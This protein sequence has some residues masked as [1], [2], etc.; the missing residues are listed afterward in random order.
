MLEDTNATAVGA[1]DMESEPA[2]NQQ[3]AAGS[4]GPKALNDNEGFTPPY[5]ISYDEVKPDE[6][7]PL[8]IG[9]DAEWIEEPEEPSD[10]TDADDPPDPDA[11]RGNL[12]LSYQYAC[13]FSGREW[14]G[15]VYTRAGARIRYPDLNEQ[16]VADYPV[17]IRFADLLGEAISAGTKAG[18]LRKWPK[19][20]I[21]AAHWTRADL[22][23]MADFAEIKREFD[24]VQKTYVTMESRYEARI[25]AG[26]RSRSFEV[27]LL[28]TQL[29]VPGATKGLG[30]L[31]EMYGFPKL[32]PGR[33]AERGGAPYIEHMDWLLEDDPSHFEGYAIKDA[34]ICALHVERMLTFARDDLG[35]DFRRPPITLGSLAV[36][37]LEKRWE[38]EGIAPGAVNGFDLV[39][40]RQFNRNNGKGYITK[41]A[42][43]PR[44]KYSIHE[45]LAKRCFH[46]G[47]NECFWY[48]PTSEMSRDL[49]APVVDDWDGERWIGEILFRE[50]DLAAAYATAL[51]SLRIPDYDNARTT[52]DPA[53]FRP[54]QLGF[55]YIRFGFP[56]ETTCFPCLPVIASDERGLVYP[57]SGE[58]YVTAPE[59]A[60]A[61]HTG[62]EI[63]V[64]DGAVI[65]WIEDSPRPFEL[66]IREL[67]RRRAEHPAGTLQNEMFKQ[68]GNSL[69]GKLGQGI[70]GSTSYNTRDDQRVEIG[71]SRITNPYLAAHVTG[72]IRALVSEMIAS[73]P[74]RWTV[75]SVT[76]DGFVTNAPISDIGMDGPVAT[77]LVGV[78]SSLTQVLMR[79]DLYDTGRGLLEV[80]YEAAW[81][82]PWRTRGVATLSRD[83]D[84]GR[85]HEH[86]LD[87]KKAPK[88]K[89]ARA[90]MREPA[91]T[92]DGNAWFVRT[93]LTREP[94]Q[95]YRSK[96]PLPFPVAHQRSA[97]HRFREL[98]R[99]MNFE[100]DFKRQLVDPVPQFVS[101]PSVG[102]EEDPRIVQHLCCNTIP[103]RT[104]TEFNAARDRFEQWR[105]KHGGQLRTLADWHRWEQFQAGTVASQNG[106]RRSKDGV[107]GQAAR[108]FRRAYVRR[109][110][111]LPG[112]SYKRAADSL[113]AAGYP[114]KEQDFK[115]ALRDKSR[116]PEH[117]IPADA[118]GVRELVCA[119][120]AIWP[121][122]DWERVV[123]DPGLDYLRKT[124][125]APQVNEPQVR[126]NAGEFQ[127]AV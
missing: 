126:G 3:P 30:A 4:R 114:T 67:S 23:A 1:S 5:E 94:G 118:P 74:D 15:I 97:D 11:L 87:P 6:N 34:Q 108:I 103:W 41:T 113:T 47:R 95:K 46:G 72:L 105:H 122:F 109:K 120:L 16:E 50:F 60:L 66:V 24:G 42:R 79:Q 56:A 107:V 96:E 77:H 104:V 85:K 123:L 20:V 22:S 102:E 98:E 117:T 71:P 70:K 93:A 68:L 45:E 51:A 101:T 81:L 89:L 88:P 57:L 43:Q 127:N 63:T 112:G 7:F 49:Y 75:V 124:D 37:Y 19:H 55:A 121:E 92:K 91:G 39:K 119:L 2:V 33:S 62:A 69:Y 58:A 29:L 65:P 35:L 86:Q 125:R 17:R 80:K 38:L 111:G 44:P 53:D 110:W 40:G 54:D 83:W 61:R 32:D 84:F 48:G 52:T 9:F 90:G 26:K 18:H 25:V 106:V 115:N 13:R 59:I 116:L 12:V 78:R 64:L 36:K 82:L 31:R 99:T 73:I 8:I 27:T 100:Y 10:D 28:D 21:A 14:S 76:T